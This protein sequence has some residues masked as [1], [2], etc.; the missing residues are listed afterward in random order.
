SARGVGW[1]RAPRPRLRP[2]S[3]RKRHAASK[4]SYCNSP[5]SARPQPS[6]T[7]CKKSRPPC[8]LRQDK[9]VT[10]TV[11]VP[12]EVK[13]DEH[14]LAITPDGVLEMT[15][16]NVSVLIEGG[17]GVDSGI[18]DADYRAAG[19]EIAAD[20]AQVW[21]RADLVLKVKEPQASEL[22]YLRDD[23]TLFTYLHLAAY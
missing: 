9:P 4:A 6:I 17:A 8:A 11:G 15:H 13:T 14:R 2:R 23:L 18:T 21:T 5:I 19:A 3:G 20:E 12:R 7:S 10:L 16:H 22:G 1:P